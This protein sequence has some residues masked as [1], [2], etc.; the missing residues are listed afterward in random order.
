[1]KTIEMTG[2]PKSAGF[3][4]KQT[5]LEKLS[6]FGYQHGKMKK[7]NNDVDI[8]VTND[9]HSSTNKMDLAKELGVDIMT[10]EELKDLFEL[11]GDE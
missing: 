8:L 7:K 11:E 9:P 1:M 5:F 10:Y 4:T 3:K 2:S 6:P